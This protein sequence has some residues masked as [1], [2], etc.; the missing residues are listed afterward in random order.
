VIKEV[1]FYIGKK[2]IKREDF[3][4]YTIHSDVIDSVVLET[5]KKYSTL[6]KDAN[7]PAVSGENK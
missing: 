4:N 7:T 6:S 3:K 2:E 1:K 5:F